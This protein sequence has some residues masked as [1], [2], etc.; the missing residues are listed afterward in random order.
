MLSYFA[1]GDTRPNGQVVDT[2]SIAHWTYY[3]RIQT[4]A[5]CPPGKASVTGT[6]ATSCWSCPTGTYSNP[7]NT[8]CVHCPYGYTSYE[9]SDSVEGCFATENNEYSS[10]NAFQEGELW[11]G[12]IICSCDCFEGF[13]MIELLVTKVSPNGTITLIQTRIRNDTSYRYYMTTKMDPNTDIASGA[14]FTIFAGQWIDNPDP[15][16]IGEVART[17]LTGY[18]VRGKDALKFVGSM[19]NENCMLDFTLMRTSQISECI[20]PTWKVGEQWIGH[21]RCEGHGHP[22]VYYAMFRLH[23]I[24]TERVGTR[25]KV[26]STVFQRNPIT[27]YIGMYNMSGDY[28]STLHRLHLLPE[29][30]SLYQENE[31]SYQENK[32]SAFLERFYQEYSGFITADTL[33]YTGSVERSSACECTGVSRSVTALMRDSSVMQTKEIGGVCS[34]WK[35]ILCPYPHNL[36]STYCWDRME[37]FCYTSDSCGIAEIQDFNLQGYV[38]IVYYVLTAI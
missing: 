12:D 35:P 16:S 34:D 24:V 30:G 19:P 17:N 27:Q 23:L 37:P 4:S 25:V 36:L 11:V 10:A 20:T 18:I 2:A 22:Y 32:Y 9:K 33:T 8:Q 1:A 15:L 6:D 5:P 31:Y 3:E 14:L 26:K 7:A 13:H 38:Y 28:D 29:S 21:F